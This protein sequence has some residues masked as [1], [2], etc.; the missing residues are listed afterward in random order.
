M[1]SILKE[2]LL[3]RAG[4]VM[5]EESEAIEHQA[6]GNSRSEAGF[7]SHR[8]PTLT[9]EDIL[10]HLQGKGQGQS[11]I[12]LRRRFIYRL[13]VALHSYGS[14]ASRTE[15][16]IERAAERLHVKVKI[17]VFPSLILLSFSDNEDEWREL[18]GCLLFLHVR[19]DCWC[20]R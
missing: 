2:K 13:A 6:K 1:S 17:A 12:R 7:M 5:E 19:A 3:E 14:S 18:V 16:L 9:E 20:P 8:N 10:Q 15:Y 4:V 11:N